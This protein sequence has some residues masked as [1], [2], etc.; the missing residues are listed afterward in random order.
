MVYLLIRILYFSTKI[1]ISFEKRLFHIVRLQYIL[2]DCKIIYLLNGIKQI[3]LSFS[4]RAV[5][6]AIQHVLKD[7][8]LLNDG[9]RI[10]SMNRNIILMNPFHTM[11]SK[12][13][14]KVTLYSIAN[15]IVSTILEK[16]S[17]AF[18]THFYHSFL[19]IFPYMRIDNSIPYGY[20]LSRKRGTTSRRF[21]PLPC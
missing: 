1:N 17:I 14:P 12:I 21:V 8:V 2:F 5:S 20:N 11:V 15:A 10:V 19:T 7:L 16:N 18:I 9:R 4:L 3:L 6:C 13:A